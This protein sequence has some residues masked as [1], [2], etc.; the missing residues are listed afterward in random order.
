[1]T[2]AYLI[3][4][5]GTVRRYVLAEPLTTRR[6]DR[7]DGDGTP[8]FSDETVTVT[9]L[10]I[11]IPEQWPHSVTIPAVLVTGSGPE[12]VENVGSYPAAVPWEQVLD[13]LGVHIAQGE[14]PAPPTPFLVGAVPTADDLPLE[15][16]PL[17][18]YLV[19]DDQVAR[20]LVDGE[21]RDMPWD[22][23]C[24]TFFGMTA[25]EV[26]DIEPN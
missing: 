16:Q 14:P 25:D 10:T 23:G 4:D 24:I 12:A 19:R 15:L 13:D 3:D 17:G 20:C 9:D 2:D 11:A 18:V 26:P 6:V 5:T 7:V 8:V 1:M 21:H 22:P